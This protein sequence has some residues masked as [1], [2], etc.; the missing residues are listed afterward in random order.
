MNAITIALLIGVPGV[1]IPV[2]YC[3]ERATDLAVLFASIGSILS[4]YLIPALLIATQINKHVEMEPYLKIG[5]L[6]PNT[7]TPNQD[8]D[9][10]SVHSMMTASITDNNGGKGGHVG[11]KVRSV[12]LQEDY[13]KG[14]YGQKKPSIFRAL[15]PVEGVGL[16]L[17][18]PWC[19]SGICL[20]TLLLVLACF[21]YTITHSQPRQFREE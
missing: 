9:M 19:V 16:R 17:V 21:V 2:F 12:Q 5:G 18:I 4:G 1:G 20:V 10:R 7:P 11:S 15:K 14:Y 3:T 6:T 8:D 13:F